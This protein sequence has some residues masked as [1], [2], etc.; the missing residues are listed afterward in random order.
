[1]L[2]ATRVGLGMVTTTA[3]A[4]LIELHGVARPG[5]FR[6]CADIV[7]TA[8]NIGGLAVGPLLAEYVT[9]PLR[10][11]YLIFLR[12]LLI[13]AAGVVLSPEAVV[14]P[15][16][17]TAYRPQRV[18]VPHAARPMFYGVAERRAYAAGSG[19]RG[20][21]NRRRERRS[22]WWTSLRAH[23]DG[24]PR[25]RRA[26]TR[27]RSRQRHLTVV[28]IEPVGTGGSD[29]LPDPREYTIAT[30]TTFLN[31]VVEHLAQQKISVLGHS[32]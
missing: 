6:T 13:S 20:S 9:S 21:A 29:R 31:A 5:A 11:P 10:T 32:Q 28:Y 16:T 14:P 17:P 8:A 3:T 12:L 25:R 7:A 26:G 15:A 22:A 24:N 27:T 23:G 18:S 1:M 19:P 4:Y 30:Y 2:I